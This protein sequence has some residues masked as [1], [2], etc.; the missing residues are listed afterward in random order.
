MGRQR[1]LW[2]DK[3]PT[4]PCN[5]AWNLR[6]C[7]KILWRYWYAKSQSRQ[8]DEKLTGQ[9]P[10]KPCKSGPCQLWWHHPK[11]NCTNYAIFNCQ[12]HPMLLTVSFESH[13]R[14][15]SGRSAQ[16]RFDRGK[17]FQSLELN[18]SFLT[19]SRMM[20]RW[21]AMSL[22]GRYLLKYSSILCTIVSC[23]TDGRRW[24]CT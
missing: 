15:A 3:R 8:L 7:K 19:Q 2:V 20:Q 10:C 6:Y 18:E 21:S 16:V 17:H 5:H 9:K 13:G 12:D 23:C 14:N 24:E 1:A 4:S 22:C 11:I